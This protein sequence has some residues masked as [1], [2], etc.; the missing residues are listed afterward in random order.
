[1]YG[2]ID[3][4][5]GI[6]KTTSGTSGLGGTGTTAAGAQTTGMDSSVGP[7]SRFGVRGSEDLDSGLKANFL[8]E[9]GFSA[10]NG[11]F[12]QGGLAWGRQAFVGLSSASG[13]SVSLG[14]QYSPLDV[15]FARSDALGGV[16]WGNAVNNSGHGII[17]SLAAAP[18]GGAFQSVGR[19]DNSVLVTYTANAVTAK[20]LVGSGNNGDS[21]GAGRVINP[22]ISYT[23]GPVQLNASY[24]WIRQNAEAILPSVSPK[25]LTEWLVGGSYTFGSIRLHA[26]LFGFNG[27]KNQNNLS[28]AAKSSPFAYTWRKTNTAW[29]GLVYSPTEAVRLTAQVA[30][31][32]FDYTA[33][34]NGRSI[35]VGLVGEYLLSKRTALYVNYGITRNNK[36]ANAPMIGAVPVVFA[37]GYGSNASALSFGMRHSF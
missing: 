14:R 11:A 29:L 9:G 34:P 2:L 1:M 22:D 13:W 8:F 31:V 5:V 3:A 25:M 27:P 32:N 33:G 28:A 6:H 7:G 30:R 24:A 19:V 10:A 15:S 18:G 4:V 37:A 23:S 12:Q 26:G 20:L 35:V 17:E 16:Y 21:R 36:Y